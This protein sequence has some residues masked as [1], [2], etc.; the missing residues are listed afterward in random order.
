[1]TF[2]GHQATLLDIPFDTAAHTYVCVEDFV[3][4]APIPYLEY[5]EAI[6]EDVNE[7]DADL[8]RGFRD[9]QALEVLIRRFT[10]S[11]APRFYTQCIGLPG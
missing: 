6:V 4:G 9:L 8:L 2:I 11:L 7:Y 1:M 5:V 10:H 3:Q